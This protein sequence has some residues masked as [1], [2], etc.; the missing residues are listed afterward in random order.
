MS[1]VW[2][3]GRVQPPRSARSKVRGVTSDS[4]CG[5]TEYGADGPGRRSSLLRRGVVDG[6]TADSLPQ[7]AAGHHRMT[8]P[9]RRSSSQGAARGF[10]IRAWGQREPVIQGTGRLS[11]SAQWLGW[12]EGGLDIRATH[13]ECGSL[14]REHPLRS[15][16]RRARSR[17]G[18]VGDVRV[19]SHR[20][21]LY[22]D[23]LP[24]VPWPNEQDPGHSTVPVRD[25][26]P[27]S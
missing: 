27:F 10:W 8:R 11:R 16:T 23:A 24:V 13:A 12:L 14:Q 19:A 4:G 20:S 3:D 25:G 9:S 18:R 15:L 7:T 6:T 5:V 17:A 2:R 1:E 21:L 26:R 22:K